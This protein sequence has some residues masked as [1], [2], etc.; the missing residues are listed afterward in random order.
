MPSVLP[1]PAGQSAN[2]V[3]VAAFA[4]GY[5]V[6]G[7]LTP[8]S[9]ATTWFSPDGAT[10]TRTFT[11]HLGGGQ[12][13]I[14]FLRASGGSLLAVGWSGVEHCTGGGEGSTCDPLPVAIWTSTDGRTWVT[15]RRPATLAGVTIRDVASGPAGYI[16][17]GDTSWVD[18]AIW[19]STDGTAWSEEPLTGGAPRAA[20]TSCGSSRGERGWVVAGSVGGEAP[21]CCDNGGATGRPAAWYSS[22]GTAWARAGTTPPVNG[23]GEIS[24]LDGGAGGLLA[25]QDP[26]RSA[27]GTSFLWAS[28]DGLAWT[29]TPLTT[30]VGTPIRS[31]ASDGRRIVWEGSANSGPLPLFVSNDGL[32]WRALAIGGA[33]DSAPRADNSAGPQIAKAILTGDGMVATGYD[34][35]GASGVV[36]VV[37]AVVVP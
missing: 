9:R 34:E 10:W 7:N 16:M 36:W 25:R 4:G 19:T 2:P 11:D 21:I 13:V 14:D 15:G 29:K 17:V 27:G 35:S 5:V 8:S 20:P 28:T 1:P 33:L 18:G 22:D 23:D 12:S 30:D 31:F 6:A 37:R 24:T 3:D 26:A 32:A